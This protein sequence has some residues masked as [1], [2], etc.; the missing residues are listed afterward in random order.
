MTMTYSEVM[1]AMPGRAFVKNLE[2]DVVA[3]MK[4]ESGYYRAPMVTDPDK[5]NEMAGVH[6]KMAEAM[7]I[8]SM[9]GFDV[10]AV[11][12]LVEEAMSET[13]FEFDPDIDGGEA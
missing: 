10:K 6:P 8:G 7:M 3:V 13:E 11:A 4:G 1:K 12:R 2:G 9:F 5:A